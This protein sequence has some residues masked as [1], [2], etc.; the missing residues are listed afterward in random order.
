[1]KEVEAMQAVSDKTLVGQR[2]EQE[3]KFSDRVEARK[4]RDA[5]TLSSASRSVYRSLITERVEG[6]QGATQGAVKCAGE[7]L[8]ICDFFGTSRPDFPDELTE[9]EAIM[10]FAMSE[11]GIMRRK[12]VLT[13][14][15]WKDGAAPMLCGD[16]EGEFYALLPA[17]D[18][19]YTVWLDGVA[20][21]VTK[22][23]AGLFSNV[24]YCFYRPF[25]NRALTLKDFALFLCGSF[26]A[27]DVAWL[28][29]VSL[30][31]G[32]LGMIM[33]MINQ[34]IFHNVI[35]SGTS[36]EILGISVLIVGTVLLQ[37]FCG[38]ARSMWVMRIGNK[39]ELLAQNAVWARLM[40]LPVDF[41]RDYSSGELSQRA[42]SINQICSI[43][44][45]QLIPTLLASVFSFVYLFQIS[46]VS[47]VL[48]LPS[49]VIVLLTLLINLGSAAVQIRQTAHNNKI[50][51]QLSGMVF[52]LLDGL[53]KIKVAGAEARAFG[54]WAEIYSKLK[55]V[56]D[57]FVLF[58]GA[59]S[60]FV[61]F[62]GTIVLY[63][64]A[65]Q[66]GMSVSEYIA[67]NTAF[68]LFVSAVM[69]MAGITSQ[70]G[71]LKPALEM[72]RPILEET[73]ET[74]GYK[75]QVSSLS[76][77]IEVNQVKF[78]YNDNM[79]NV[80]DGLELHIK[81]GE[82]IGIVGSSGC[83]KSTLMRVLLGFEKPQSGSVYYDM[84]DMNGL[85]LRSVRRRIGVVLQNGKLFSGDIY[86]NIVI[87]A[88]W[89]SVD[90]AW[91]AAERSGFAE[92]IRKM[93]MKMFTMI[94]EG[95]GG[96][97]GG[98]QQRLL[99]ARAL[100][101]NPDIVMF[102]EATSAL[103]N[104]TQALVVKTLEEMQCTRLVIAHR[105]STI[106]GCSRIIYL[107]KG[108]V[109]ESG[110]YEELMAMNGRFAEMAKRQMV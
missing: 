50:E 42:A 108:K 14:K 91:A 53:T 73:P 101:S 84:Q 67:F 2:T 56:P 104:I 35:P 64:A 1:M 69:S 55:I 26:R 86:S 74:A 92:D 94:S 7:L 59:I 5:E 28:L 77:E 80:L 51:S 24:C 13:G 18:G 22:K 105:L 45:G 88:P 102:D 43:L 33:P 52:Q 41:F 93:P 96:L 58:S 78:R 66:A 30:L 54:K 76:G 85:D 107:H 11:T 21:K 10:Q 110:T 106:K 99:I 89:L 70:I 57:K 12:V 87:C 61:S 90:E 79:P 100:A 71:S 15:W 62:G 97:S 29:A 44:G 109:V 60:N 83:G 47:P 72:L 103:D 65:Y 16:M 39:M 27:A 8:R 17:S 19:G 81:P 32:L 23:K 6:Q 48:L 63:Y 9:P 46:T 75:K 37:A 95:G 68:S 20:V 34:F 4:L 40:S 25:E 82:Y 3:Q 49:L 31:A 38:L 98:Q 36:Q